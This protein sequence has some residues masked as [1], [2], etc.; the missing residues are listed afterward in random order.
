M[1]HAQG[2]EPFLSRAALPVATLWLSNSQQR[3]SV[4]TGRSYALVK[5]FMAVHKV[6]THTQKEEDSDMCS[7]S[8]LA[9]FGLGCHKL[10]VYREG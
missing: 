9:L 6:K 4:V 5:E 2:P 10:S 7:K 3:S 1:P 8:F